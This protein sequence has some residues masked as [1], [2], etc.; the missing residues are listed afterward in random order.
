MG[1][2]PLALLLVLVALIWSRRGPHPATYKMSEPWTHPPILWTADEPA[3][4]GHGGHGSHLTV[5]GG[6]S[7]KW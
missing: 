6:A 4:H 3:D 1:G 7:G 2:I 5:G